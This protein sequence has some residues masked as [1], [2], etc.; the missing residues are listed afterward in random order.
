LKLSLVRHIWGVDLSNG[1]APY[2]DHWRRIGYDT[3]EASLQRVPDADL[4][5]KTLK[6]E[7]LGWIAQVFSNMFVPGGTVEQHLSSLKSQIDECLNAEPLFFNCHSGSDTWSVAEAEEFF[8]A[9]LE[10]ERKIGI[11]LSHETHRSR[12]FAN[13][14][15]THEI[16]SRLQELKITC[17]LSHWVCVAERLLQDCENIIDLCATR[18]H[19]VHARVGHEEGPQ[20]AD[21]RAPEWKAHLETH[22]GWWKKIWNAQEAR[23]CA[24]S[25]LTPEFGPP[26]YL[27]TIP[28]TN[29]PVADLNAICDWMAERERVQFAGRG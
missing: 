11:T 17:D 10:M 24:I 14:W 27:P 21:P 1:L 2:I 23:G 8:G 22:E 5:L 16:L 13:P 20:V 28:W 9:A 19:H 18:C 29:Q 15:T 7:R 6:K 3:I 4:F 12:Y 26:P 25:T